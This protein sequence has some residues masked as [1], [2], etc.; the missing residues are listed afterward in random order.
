[1]RVSPDQFRTLEGFFDVVETT[2]SVTSTSTQVAL[3]DPSRWAILFSCLSSI[4]IYLSTTGNPGN[5]QGLLAPA[6]SLP[7]G[8]TFQ[9]YP[10]LPAQAWWAKG[11]AGTGTLTV[12]ECKYKTRG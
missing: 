7:L 11:N 3:A 1:M 9:D 12:I 10:G 2:Y 6:N 5:Q 8:F 4:T